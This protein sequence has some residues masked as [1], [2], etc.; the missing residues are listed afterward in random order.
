MRGDYGNYYDLKLRL[1]TGQITPVFYNSPREIEP[2]DDQISAHLET[3]VPYEL[4]IIVQV[5]YVKYTPAIAPEVPFELVTIESGTGATAAKINVVLQGKVLDS[6]WNVASQEYLAVATPKIYE[7]RYVLL[8]T[9]IG[10][11]IVN[12]KIL[13]EDLGEQVDEIVA[14]GYLNWKPSR[15]DLLA[16][17]QKSVDP[18]P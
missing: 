18:E 15:L 11:I 5:R 10:K 9:A 16:I 8:E 3:G 2:A 14:G 1:P 12:Y 17:L 7:R 4:L 13:K 6:F